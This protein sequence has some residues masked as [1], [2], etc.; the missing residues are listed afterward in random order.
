MFRVVVVNPENGE[1]KYC[2]DFELE[3]EKVAQQVIESLKKHMFKAD[4][5]YQIEPE[6]K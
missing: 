4:Y 2:T 6:G 5:E 1:I 3:T